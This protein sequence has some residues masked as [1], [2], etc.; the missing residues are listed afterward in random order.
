[1]AIDCTTLGFFKQVLKMWLYKNSLALSSFDVFQSMLVTV[2]EQCDK[3]L[4]ALKQEEK[5]DML[6]LKRENR[7]LLGKISSLR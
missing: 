5:G 2:S 1:M 6:E 4:L 3:K 7:R